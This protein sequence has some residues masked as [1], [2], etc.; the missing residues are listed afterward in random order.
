MQGFQHGWERLA[1]QATYFWT[2]TFFCLFHGFTLEPF[3]KPFLSSPLLGVRCHIIPAHRFRL[4][5]NQREQTC[6]RNESEIF[7]AGR[8]VCCTLSRIYRG[9]YR[10][11]QRGI[12]RDIG[13]FIEKTARH[14]SRDREMS[15]SG[16][17][18]QW[19]VSRYIYIYI[20]ARCYSFLK[21]KVFES[22]VFL[23]RNRTRCF[24]LKARYFARAR[25]S[26]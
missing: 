5:R 26:R 24:S 8:D 17:E 19:D 25:C 23:S 16:V 18:K 21:G 20:Y 3:L 6:S 1:I 9:V 11:A 13:V 14:F 2:K 7:L 15:R 10:K 12:S 22:D 4:T